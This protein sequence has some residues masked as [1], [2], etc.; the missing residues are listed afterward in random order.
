TH[1]TLRLAP[2]VASVPVIGP[3]AADA[4]NLFGDY[5]YPAHV[6]SL[7]VLLDS[8]GA[9]FAREEDDAAA[10][11]GI[12]VG[13][14]TVLDALRARLGAR[15]RYAQGCDVEGSARDGFAEAVALAREA[16]VE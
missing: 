11:A 10:A 2:S 1:D 15:V 8:G 4:R 14:A 9:P 3:S 6:E 12:D 5:A 16:D 13:A 7:R